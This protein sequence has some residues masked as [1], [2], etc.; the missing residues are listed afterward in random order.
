MP[1][2]SLPLTLYPSSS[3]TLHPSPLTHFRIT[4]F[5]KTQKK[6]ESRKRKSLKHAS[7]KGNKKRKGAA[8]CAILQEEEWRARCLVILEGKL[9]WS[10][11]F[12]GARSRVHSIS[13]TTLHYYWNRVIC[14]RWRLKSDISISTVKITI[15]ALM[16]SLFLNDVFRLG[17]TLMV[18]VCCVKKT[19]RCTWH[20][21]LQS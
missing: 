21:R 20:W 17:N 1:P 11:V 18:C 2:H 14:V 9:M 3:L 12:W 4:Q 16:W 5:E 6:K 19:E 8:G 13:S 7:V 15:F 10:G